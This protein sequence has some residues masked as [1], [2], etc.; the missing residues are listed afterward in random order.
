MRKRVVQPNS[1]VMVCDVHGEPFTGDKQCIGERPSSLGGSTGS[2]LWTLMDLPYHTRLGV[3]GMKNGHIVT[4]EDDESN[5]YGWK[6]TRSSQCVNTQ[7]NLLGFL[8]CAPVIQP[9]RLPAVQL[10]NVIYDPEEDAMY[11]H[12]QLDKH[13]EMF[14]NY[15]CKLDVERPH[16][17][18][19]GWKYKKLSS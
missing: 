8:Q 5:G 12:Y 1:D 7:A 14:W 19:P 6:G 2:G 10:A 9:P 16:E 17:L 15:G 11:T 18:P 3:L 13:V 4:V